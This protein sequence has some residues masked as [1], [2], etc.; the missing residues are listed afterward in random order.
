MRNAL[1][2]GERDSKFNGAKEER[3]KKDLHS[4]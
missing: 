4:W 3:K 1:E 2:R